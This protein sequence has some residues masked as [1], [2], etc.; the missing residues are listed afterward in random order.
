MKSS[1]TSE[2]DSSHAP[3]F[4]VL[5]AA[6]SG[7]RLGHTLPK[8][9]V[10]LGGVPMF[11]RATEGLV[12]AGVNAIVITAPT[13]ECDH[14]RELIA[15]GY[16][17]NLTHPQTGHSVPVAVVAGG[18]SRQAS[19]SNGLSHIETL[20][21]E[22]HLS[23]NEKSVI[24]IH[25]AAR[26]LTPPPVIERVVHAV[27]AGSTAVIPALPVTD[28]LKAIDR[29]EPAPHAIGRVSATV[30]RNGLV[31]VQ[32]PQ[33][34]TWEVIHHAHGDAHHLADAEELAATDDAGV[35]EMAGGTVTIVN[36]DP[37]ALKITTSWD[38]GIAEYILASEN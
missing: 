11:C 27:R 12:Q 32:T 16:C 3:V 29:T 19:V 2:Q 5:T 28:T 25:D 20:A 17:G 35:V 4:A 14:F 7:S 36:G 13:D 23:I 24:L 15:H 8:A 30:D 6:G 38:L 37:R 10:P 22:H 26:A 18:N 34:F 21:K 1:H 9:L 31:S 33:G